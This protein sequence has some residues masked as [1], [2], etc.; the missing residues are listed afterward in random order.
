MSISW[1]LQEME[2]H[3]VKDALILDDQSITYKT[4]LDHFRQWVA[5]LKDI[6]IQPGEIVALQGDYSPL[7]CA[8]ILALIANGNITVPLSS[9]VDS[10]IPKLLDIAEVQV[11][12]TCDGDRY[13]VQRH[14][15][16]VS[17]PILVDLSNRQEPGLVLFS[18]GST[19]FPKGIVHNFNKLLEKYKKKRN[20]LRTL[21]FL[22]FDHIGGI[23][24]LFH[25]LAN[26]GTVICPR[27]RTVHDIVSAIEKHRVELIP[28]TPSFLN[29]L[30]LQDA[31][32]NGDL[33]SLKVITYGT[34]MMHEKTL[35]H[36]CQKLPEVQFKQTYGLSE[37]GIMSSK[38][39]ASDSLWLKIGGEGIETKIENNILFIR[40]QTAMKGYLN[41]PSPFDDEGW[42]NTQDQVM[43]DGEYIRFLGRKSEMINVGGQK[44]YPAEVENLLLQMPE[45]E[46]VLVKGMPNALLGSVVS[47]VV[48]TSQSMSESEI[49]KR[50]TEF[51][52]GKIERFKIPVYVI[53]Q[54]NELHSKRFKKIRK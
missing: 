3:S 48:N 4:L 29:L 23:N 35:I 43:T 52:K 53:I 47:A 41:A 21:A 42:F 11:S 6:E 12:F 18:S 14:A 22:L 50:I 25:T 10:D 30:L 36:L 37:L 33:S 40:S 38:S 51:C 8:A 13:H 31:G 7:V 39:Q 5:I 44:V 1:L 16:E 19:G 28:T 34:E 46:D 45:I 2:A 27:G 15:R 54:D 9:M 32:L 49:K 26:G 24:T 17:H 20:T